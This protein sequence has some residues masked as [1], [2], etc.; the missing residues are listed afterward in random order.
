MYSKDSLTRPEALIA[1][2]RRKGIDRVVVTDHNC[3]AGALAASMLDPE[4]VIVG[5]EIMTTRGEL[6]AA[7][8]QSEVP[9]G[10][11]PLEAIHRLRQQG[12]FISVSHPFDVFRSGHWKLDDL[13]DILPEIDAIETYNSRCMFPVYNQ[14]AQ[15]FAR[16]H[17]LPGTVGSDAHTTLELGRAVLLLEEFSNADQLRACLR[18]GRPR[19]RWSPPW[20]HLLSRYAVWRKR[21]AAAFKP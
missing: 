1:T 16:Q 9:A 11:P 13:L 17:D 20:F 15:T 14:R 3:I 6:L 21:R 12:A 8:V 10:L 5:E 4:L 7:F 18:A 2:S 19:V